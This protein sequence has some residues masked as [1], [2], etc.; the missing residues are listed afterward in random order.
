MAR[1]TQEVYDAHEAAMVA[2]DLEMIMADYAD[3]AIL[4]TVDGASVGKEAIQSWFIT[5]LSSFPGIK[6]TF[7][8]TAVE[9]DTAILN[10]SADSDVAT[11][12]HGVAGY[13]IQDGMIKRHTEWFHVAPKEA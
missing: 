6:F 5:A 8:K 9:G 4:L 3:D 7:E 13:I 10:W 2:G 1:T 12:P 11:I